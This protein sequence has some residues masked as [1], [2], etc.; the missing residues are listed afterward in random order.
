M[1]LNIASFA[2]D[3]VFSYVAEASNEGEIADFGAVTYY[4]VI[5]DRNVF[6]NLNVGAC[7]YAYAFLWIQH[8]LTLRAPDLNSLS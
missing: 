2:Y 8:K 7:N 5:P 6:A 1:C 4:N 3:Y